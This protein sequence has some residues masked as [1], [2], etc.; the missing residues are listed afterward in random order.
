MPLIQG[1][2]KKAISKNI[3]KEMEAGKP[4]KQ[5]IAIAYAV[6]K[7]NRKRKFLGGLVSEGASEFDNSPDKME[8]REDVPRDTKRNPMDMLPKGSDED[9]R[10]YF[11]G[12]QVSEEAAEED[13]SPYKMSERERV[14]RRNLKGI[15][16]PLT[17]EADSEEMK[18]ARPEYAE[19]GPVYRFHNDADKIGRHVESEHEL[20][21]QRLNWDEEDMDTEAMH[22]YAEGG[23]V[24]KPKLGSGKRFEHL[25]HSLAHEKDIKDPAALAAS[26]GRKK[27]GAEKMAKLA[28][29]KKM[30]EGGPVY[31]FH[32]DSDHIGTHID[33]EHELY[34][35]RLNWDEES[36]HTEAMD[37]YAEGGSVADRIMRKKRMAEGGS[38]DDS[39]T[40]SALSS[41][42]QALGGKKAKGGMIKRYADGGEVDLNENSMEQ[43]NRYYHQNEDVVLKENYDDDF[44]D[45]SQPED[46]NEHSDA[47]DSDE[48]DMVSKIRKK[49]RSLR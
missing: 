29:H 28:E 10:K 34:P 41:I 46:S 22:E 2:S 40:G 26:I 3:E 14:A 38:I 47:I 44:K 42:R 43:P 7:K 48:H 11:L 1:K 37:E 5:S 19:G 32:N 39:A 23:S 4:Q 13:R 27:Y 6:A 12:G 8:Y 9:G 16:H 49:M 31:E 45:D 33:E 35:Q 24:K 20:Y 17:E 15:M 21:P 18:H 30:A 25:E 36:M